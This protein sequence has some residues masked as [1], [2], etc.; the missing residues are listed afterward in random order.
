MCTTLA[1]LPTRTKILPNGTRVALSVL[2]AGRT[3]RCRSWD[4]PVSC[5]GPV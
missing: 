2:W 3:D 5:H 1:I 4:Q